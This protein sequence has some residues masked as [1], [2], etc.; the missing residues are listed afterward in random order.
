MVLRY[1]NIVSNRD[2]G[3]RVFLFTKE[4]ARVEQNNVLTC[5]QSSEVANAA[6]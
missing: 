2:E 4:I 3:E 5:S 1:R 6:K